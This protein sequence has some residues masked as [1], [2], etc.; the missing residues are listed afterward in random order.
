MTTLNNFKQF[1]YNE[2]TLVSLINA[3][4]SLAK[5]EKNSSDPSIN[6][7]KKDIGE[8]EHY[9]FILIDGLGANLLNQLSP[10]GLLKN[11]LYKIIRTV[12]PSTTAS[13]ITSLTTGAYPSTHSITGWWT[14]L[15]QYNL[16]STVLP[17]VER[18]SGNSLSKYFIKT[19][20]VFLLPSL[21]EKINY[22]F[23]SYIPL[24][25][26][27]SIFSTYSSGRKETYGYSNLQEAL[28]KLSNDLQTLNEPSLSY[29][30]YPDLDSTSHA[31]GFTHPKNIELLHEIDTKLQNFK[32]N[33][34]T[35][36]RI[37]ITAD[38]GHTIIPKENQLYISDDNPLMSY[39]QFPPSG[40]P[41]V[42][43][44]HVKKGF[45]KVF[46][47][48]FNETYGEYFYLLSKK[49]VE[50]LQLLGP[51]TI[52]LETQKRIGDFLAIAKGD[53]V[54]SY[55]R[56]KGTLPNM[57]GFHAGL[58]DDEMNIPVFLI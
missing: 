54:L 30:Y 41:R 38:H 58:S 45:N 11:S 37:V 7:L 25:F 4:H 46:K 33:L 15:P 1:T 48:I 20:E 55:L 42:P 14:Y 6:Q 26:K 5:N 23:K 29:I 49:E 24:E 28:E 43:I 16:T 9:V 44:F 17:F 40:E 50:K 47:K 35:K 34:S 51:G 12:F 10:N 19:E 18:F 36:V 32:N 3:L 21:F 31:H 56:P 27:G 52:T 13:A 53:H 57:V 2:P 39:L 22:Y 8:Y